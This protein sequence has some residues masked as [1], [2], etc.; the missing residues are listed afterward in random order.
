MHFQHS[1]VSK[2]Y[3]PCWSSG[4]SV[5]RKYHKT[6]QPNRQYSPERRLYFVIESFSV[7]RIT[8][9]VVYEFWWR[10][11]GGLGCVSSRKKNKQILFVIR[12]RMQIQES[13]KEYF[14]RWKWTLPNC[15]YGELSGLRGSLWSSTASELNYLPNYQEL[16]ANVLTTFRRW[17]N[18][19]LLHH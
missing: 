12:I 19:P 11:F 18:Q 5:V 3:W 14:H 4:T 8:W 7:S 2:L 6:V 13:L 1:S 17:Q 10:I 16:I 15:S 9:N